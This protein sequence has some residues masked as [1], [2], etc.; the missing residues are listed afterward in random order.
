MRSRGY[1]FEVK[2]LSPLDWWGPGGGVKRLS[3]VTTLDWWR[4]GGGVIERG[5]Q[6]LSLLTGGK[7]VRGVNQYA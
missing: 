6:R 2:R 1:Q 4:S 7:V 3:E 5:Y